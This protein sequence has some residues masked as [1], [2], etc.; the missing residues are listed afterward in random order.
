MLRNGNKFHRLE[1][2]ETLIE[3]VTML[4]EL[5][6]SVND[7]TNMRLASNEEFPLSMFF[8]NTIQYYRKYLIYKK[9]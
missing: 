4:I 7:F 5:G 1:L 8:C 3:Q 2:L 9:L 6:N